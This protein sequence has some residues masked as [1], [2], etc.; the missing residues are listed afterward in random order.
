MTPFDNPVVTTTSQ[1]TTSTKGKIVYVA[2]PDETPVTLYITSGDNQDIALSLTL[3]PK[4]I[5]AREIH[6]GLDKDTYKVLTK[7]Q[8]QNSNAVGKAAD[9]EQEYITTLSYP[10]KTAQAIGSDD[11]A[12][13]EVLVGPADNRFARKTGNRRHFNSQGPVFGVE[14]DGGH[15]GHFI[16]GTTTGLAA[17]QFT[18]EISVIH[19]DIA[20]QRVLSIPFDHR[21]HQLLLYQPS[22]GVAHAQLPFKIE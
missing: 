18:T 11:T 14:R 13:S 15:K 16:L 22:R 17:R 19:L 4:R 5:P 20:T 21:L 8:Q 12:W 7:L 1:A 2:T 9:K 3:I 6:L 10:G